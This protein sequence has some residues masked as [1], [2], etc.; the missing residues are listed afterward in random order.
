MN[1][2]YETNLSETISEFFSIIVKGLAVIGILILIITLVSTQSRGSDLVWTRDYHVK[3][4]NSE[5]KVKYIYFYDLQCPACK[6][7]DPVL[8]EVQDELKDKVE[9]VYRNFPLSIHTF[10]K[11]AAYGAQAISKQNKDLYFAFKEEIFARQSEL[12]IT[13]IEETGKKLA[14]DFDKWNKDRNSQE[15]KDQIE[16]DFNFINSLSFKVRGQTTKATG[17]PFAIILKDGETVDA[18]GGGKTKDEQVSIINSY[19][20]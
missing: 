7:N 12:S 8:K 1:G 10:A 20:D 15:I 5:S 3:V 13:V 16:T 6:A 17:T 18:W 9:F 11:S 2:S 19:L 4:G 14:P